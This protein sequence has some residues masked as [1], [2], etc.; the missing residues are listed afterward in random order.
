LTDAIDKLEPIHNKW[1][2]SQHTGSSHARVPES[3]CLRDPADLQPFVEDSVHWVFKPVFSRFASQTRIGPSRAEAAAL[4]PNK[5][6]PWIAQRRIVGQ[7]Y[8]SYS[9]AHRGCLRAHALYRS[10]YRIGHGSG[11]Y[12]VPCEHPGIA[13][14][15]R[16]FVAAEAY[17]GQI[18]FDFIVDAA[19]AVWVLEANPRATS[20]VHLFA[21]ADRLVDALLGRSD[22]CVRPTIAEPC[23]LGL[24]MALWGLPAALRRGQLL[25]FVRDCRRAR[26]VAWKWCDPLP[27]L[28]MPL[29]LAELVGLALRARCQLTEAATCDIEWNGEP[30]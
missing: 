29:A 2:F 9:V 11:I 15:V 8:S 28:L 19:D 16:D 5:D 20:G 17:T 10:D 6:R 23:M 27:S 24:P 4:K 18:G 21:A 1:K 22:G 12:F 13:A 30:L 14:F 3:H 26:E 7:E 25:R